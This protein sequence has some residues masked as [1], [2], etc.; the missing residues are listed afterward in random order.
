MQEDVFL[1]E[2]VLPMEMLSSMGKLDITSSTTH[3][4]ARAEST[5]QDKSKNEPMHAAKSFLDPMPKKQKKTRHHDVIEGRVS[6]KAVKKLVESLRFALRKMLAGGFHRCDG[7]TVC[8]CHVD[9]QYHS[10]HMYMHLDMS[11]QQT[12]LWHMSMYVISR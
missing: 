4:S 10:S 3:M 6:K 7:T 2:G 9:D 11:L 1:I 12:P 5:K 8:I